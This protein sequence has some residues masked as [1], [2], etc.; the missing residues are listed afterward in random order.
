[1]RKFRVILLTGDREIVH[2]AYLEVGKRS[3]SF[4]DKNFQ[5]F[6]AFPIAAVQS[7]I[8]IKEE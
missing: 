2:A 3:Y 4:A 5:I 6:A 8:E 1:M 7:I